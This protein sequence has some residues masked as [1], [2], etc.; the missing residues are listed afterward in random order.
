[1]EKYANQSLLLVNNSSTLPPK[2]PE[3][4]FYDQVQ[5]EEI[6]SSLL[7]QVSSPL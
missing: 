5:N 1:M 6:F 3:N 2:N 7:F 4:F